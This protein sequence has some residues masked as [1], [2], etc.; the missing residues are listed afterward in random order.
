M[1][2]YVP[3][4]DKPS[5]VNKDGVMTI[6]DVSPACQKDP[7]SFGLTIAGIDEKDL[8]P[9]SIQDALGKVALNAVAEDKKKLMPDCKT[10]SYAMPLGGD[11]IGSK[12]KK[13]A[14]AVICL[15][16]N[17]TVPSTLTA[18]APVTI[19]GSSN[20][21]ASMNAGGLNAVLK[22]AIT[23]KGLTI[24]GKTAEKPTFTGDGCTDAERK[25]AGKFAS[26]ACGAGASPSPSPSGGGGDSGSKGLGG[27]S[28]AAIVAG[29]VVALIIAGVVGA[30]YT[31]K[32]KN[33]FKGSDTEP[34]IDPSAAR[35]VEDG[36]SK[37]ES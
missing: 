13:L 24:G 25:N 32:M 34:L 11:T 10:S 30:V 8:T 6:G 28:I 1:D 19:T 12:T 15:F 18:G 35:A 21:G 26:S 4:A 7:K 3:A 37:E 9:A 22:D 14:S 27:G 5:W 31:G 29:A 20:A 33:P 16:D 2:K 36:A 23:K 17:I